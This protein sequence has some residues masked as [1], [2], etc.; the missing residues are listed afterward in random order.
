VNKF[1][2]AALKAVDSTPATRTTMRLAATPVAY[3]H[4]KV[5]DEVLALY[6]GVLAKLSNPG[7]T[8]IKAWIHYGPRLQRTSYYGEDS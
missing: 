5:A 4:P 2:D 1:I 7:S 8:D 3:L 6:R